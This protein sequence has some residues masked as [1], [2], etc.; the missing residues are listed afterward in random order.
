MYTV[1]GGSEAIALWYWQPW[2]TGVHEDQISWEHFLYI[3]VSGAIS[4]YA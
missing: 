3:L 2:D 1:C 4:F